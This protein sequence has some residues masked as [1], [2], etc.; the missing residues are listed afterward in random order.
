MFWTVLN[1][2]E[3]TKKSIETGS[4]PSRLLKSKIPGDI[5][6]SVIQLKGRKCSPH[7]SSSVIPTNHNTLPQFSQTQKVNSNVENFF[8]LNN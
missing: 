6:N 2:V 3:D 7:F 1:D 8:F 4:T 5:K